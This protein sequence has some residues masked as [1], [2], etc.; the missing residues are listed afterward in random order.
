MINY[1]LS[2]DI[3][4]TIPVTGLNTG[5]VNMTIYHNGVG[6]FS[7]RAYNDGSTA[8]KVSLNDI[9]MQNHGK[10]DYLKLQPNGELLT[11]PMVEID[12]ETMTYS[13]FLPG[14]AGNYTV[15]LRDASTH[16]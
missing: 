6:V 4:L 7:G 14:Q 15:T 8:I 11:S 12:G 5:Y 10:N 9:A 2:D 13:R 16:Q 1:T 3:T